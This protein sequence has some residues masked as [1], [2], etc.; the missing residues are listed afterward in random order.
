[1]RDRYGA[2]VERL[3]A[4]ME[5]DDDEDGQ[6]DVAIAGRLMAEMIEAERE[7]LKAMRSERAFPAEC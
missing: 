6:T 4:R 7:V 3:E 5:G 1:M 2:R